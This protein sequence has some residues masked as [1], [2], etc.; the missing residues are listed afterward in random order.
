[1]SAPPSIMDRARLLHADKQLMGRLIEEGDGEK[2]LERRTRQNDRVIGV[3]NKR[4]RGKTYII[5]V[6]YYN[7]LS[8]A[9]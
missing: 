6:R 3:R 2:R 7:H 4:T 5:L 1:M 9:R 8:R